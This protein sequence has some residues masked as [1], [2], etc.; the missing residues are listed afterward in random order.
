MDGGAVH[1]LTD[2][3]GVFHDLPLEDLK[4]IDRQIRSLQKAQARCRKTAGHPNAKDYLA[5]GA[6]KRY[7]RLDREISRLNAHATRIVKDAQHKMTTRLVRDNDIIV[8]EDL[9]VRNMIRRPKA[10]PDPLKP[11]RYLPNGRA[12]KRSLNRVMQRAALGRVYLAGVTLILVNPA[13]T[14]QTCSRCGYVAKENRENQADFH[15]G[16][17]GLTM[18][19][20]VNAAINILSK[21]LRETEPYNPSDWGRDTSPAEEHQTFIR[22]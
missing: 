14:S 16:E 3:N 21:G 5:H 4:R 15:C 20:D 7:R 1:E 18:N 10:K 9:Q 22:R 17:C 13:Y 12:A 11:G 8:V 2:S 6:S 19:A